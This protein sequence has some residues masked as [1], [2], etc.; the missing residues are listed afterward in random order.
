[1]DM[2][3]RMQNT[4]EGK[5]EETRI[6]V[7][8]LVNEE[9]GLDI[10]CVR[11]V[12]KPQEIHPLPQ[13]PDF[14]EGVIN[15]RGHIIAVIDLI[16]KFNIKTIEDRTKMRIIICKIRK[17]IVGLAVNSVSEI[18]VLS[19]KDIQPTPAVISTQV[20]VGFISG[21]ARLGERII[22]ILN[23]EDFLPKEEMTKLSKMKV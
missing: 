3:Q 2:G 1:M 23:L 14:I 20:D 16:K 10:S 15:L 11:E 22:I 6:L 13:A 18:I 8:N 12:L 9:L 17:F 21:I 4:D 7:F 5:K 19:K